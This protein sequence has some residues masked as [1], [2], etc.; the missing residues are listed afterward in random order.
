M[1]K[2]II[3]LSVLV[4]LITVAA[5]AQAQAAP[6]G[7]APV[8]ADPRTGIDI[9]WPQCGKALPSGQAYAIVGVN[10]GTAATKNACLADQLKWANTN[11]AGNNA[12]QPKLQLYVNTANPYDDIPA[13]PNTVWPTSNI[14]PKGTNTL[15]NTNPALKNPYGACVTNPSTFKNYDNSLACSWQYGWDR[16]VTTVQD[17]F[18]PTAQ[19]V[20]GVSASP[21][22][23]VWWLDVE[24][25][26]SWQLNGSAEA[27]A[28]N[29]ASLEGMKQYYDSIGAK[30]VGLYSTSYQW[31]VIVGN[32][33]NLPTSTAPATGANLK[34]LDSWLA[35]A[36][37]AADAK[38]RCVNAVGLT[39]GKATLIQ[40]ISRNLDYNY[41]CV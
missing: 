13:Y 20:A 19:S 25:M 17:Y 37:S 15:D 26:N 2:K 16:S 33:T 12:N 10:G 35:G 41:S 38:K 8:A 5:S 39:G 1:F 31:G 18:V 11:T 29:T 40:Y 36:S 24:T 6:K 27:K 23:Y 14:D 22:D 9:S 4:A 34:G 21:A 32:T 3:H 30:K 28:R 7:S